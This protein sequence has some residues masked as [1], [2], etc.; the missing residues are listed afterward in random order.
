M[1][2]S[3]TLLLAILFLWISGNAQVT[4]TFV[5]TGSIQTYT[6]PTGVTSV[7]V[8]ARGGCGGN[9]DYY[10][11]GGIYNSRGGYGAR[12]VCSLA[13]TSGQVLY[14]YVGGNVDSANWSGTGC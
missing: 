6:V 11:F 13:V 9:T 1:N 14:V 4:S 2:K 7:T 12:V 5:Y 10:C 3:F 8:D